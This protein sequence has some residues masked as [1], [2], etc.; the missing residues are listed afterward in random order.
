MPSAT[1]TAD[2]ASVAMPFFGASSFASSRIFENSPRS[3]ARSIADG[4]VPRIGIPAASSP[5]ASPSAV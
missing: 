4:E 3:S 5:L 2:G 1:R